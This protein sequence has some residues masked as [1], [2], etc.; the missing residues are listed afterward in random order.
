MN[1]VKGNKLRNNI[2]PKLIENLDSLARLNS[3]SK[4]HRSFELLHKKQIKN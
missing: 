4:E 1:L 3:E 2:I